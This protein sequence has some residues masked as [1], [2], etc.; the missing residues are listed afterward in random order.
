MDTITLE[1]DNFISPAIGAAVSFHSISWNAGEKQSSIPSGGNLHYHSL[2]SGGTVEHTHEFGELILMLTGAI[3]H[4]VNGER[5]LL[6]ANDV[7]FVRPSDRHGFLPAPG[8]PSCELLLL[9]FHLEF[10]VTISQYL[11]N[12]EFLH[13]YTEGVLP[14]VFHLSEQQMNELSLALLELNERRYSP[15]QLKIR[16]KVLL[17]NLFTRC[18]LQAAEGAPA[19]ALP[20]WLRQLCDRMRKPEN[21]IPGLKRMQQLSGYTPE[22]LCK[23]FRRHLGKSPTEYINELR[24]NHAARLL[25]DGNQAI[26]EIAYEL[27]IQSLSRFYHLF[28][29]QYA[30]TPVEYRRR[31]QAA[32]RL[33]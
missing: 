29:A 30:C 11:E 23:M 2:P 22:H 33:L 1:L 3:I 20:D 10:F 18:F 19:E 9:S 31:A 27:N 32:R 5:Q 15:V 16:F 21:F 17:V 25:A 13:R 7:V 4:R 26:A 8:C 12:D 28:R 14:A 24:I 6:H